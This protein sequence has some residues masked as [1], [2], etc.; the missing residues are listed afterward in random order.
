[1][2][3]DPAVL[4]KLLLVGTAR[5]RLNADA[6]A[7][8]LAAVVQPSLDAPDSTPEGQLWLAAAAERLW[9]RAG[10]TPPPAPAAAAP[11]PSEHLHACPR[12]AEAI[13][14]QLLGGSEP[15]LLL[16]W[17]HL[18][19]S[20]QARLPERFLPN[21]LEE[22]T[23]VS[24]LRTG[25]RA[26]LGMRGQWLARFEPAWSWA[27]TV[28]GGSPQDTWLNGA[29]D[30]RVAALEA[31]RRIDPDAAR[32]GLQ[33]CWA[34]EPLAQ[35][36]AFLPCL[37]INLGAAD[38]PFLDAALDD[39]GKQVR[40]AAQR[41][42][43]RLPGSALSQRMLARVSALLQLENRFLRA[44]RLTVV[45][46]GECD[47]AMA[48]DG[49][50]DG[51]YPGLG[52]KAGWL[53]DMLS[54]VDPAHWLRQFG[55]P[56]D[57]FLALA[58]GT[59]YQ[60]ALLLGW[61][62]ALKLHVPHALDTGL[63]DWLASW[64]RARLRVEGALNNQHET[65]FMETYA[66]LPAPLMHAAMLVFVRESSSAWKGRDV[67]LVR[68]LHH[69]AEA[70]DSWPPALSFEI[71]QRL[72]GGLPELSINQLSF[73][74]ALPVFAAALDPAAVLEAGRQW[75]GLADDPRGWRGPVD[76]FFHIVRLRHDL[77]LS[78]Q[79]HA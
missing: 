38:E 29:P 52:E 33:S 47:A 6:L 43:A 20:R 11:C 77:A 12:A 63:L 28:T 18:L 15:R 74:Y 60:D 76:K 44:P 70:G 62:N 7:P 24:A 50:G 9:S 56:P 22:A 40:M 42:L 21:V 55:V 66:V 17:L 71:A 10:Y 4:R 8:E 73:R 67:P 46:P 30:E 78:F 58:A 57:T 5:A 59:D 39:R 64:T 69:L 45:L 53:V 26:A 3:H 36:V 35:R 13:L 27:L 54:V 2:T 37:G 75:A 65:A 72:L 14:K 49:V 23:R 31:W 79:E 34:S 25:V 1:M 19:N 41:L 16:E 48:R 32:A 51:K 61:T 68:L